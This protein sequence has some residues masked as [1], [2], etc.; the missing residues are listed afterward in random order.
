MW[1]SLLEICVQ[2]LKLIGW[3][4]FV[5]DLIKCSHPETIPYRNSSN[6]E[7]CNT[8]FPLKH[9]SNQI[10]MY[11]ISFEIFDIKQ[12]YTQEKCKY[13]NS[14]RIFPYFV[15]FFYWN[16]TSKKSSRKEDMRKMENCKAN[17]IFDRSSHQR[18]SVKKAVLRN[19]AKIHSKHLC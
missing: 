18:C 15:S 14:I 4:V 3:V 2:S 8:K 5:V 1:S 7:N 16:E 11:Q 10:T 19:F 9:S 6:H 17:H 12:T 13:L